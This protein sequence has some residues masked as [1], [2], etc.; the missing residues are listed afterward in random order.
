[1]SKNRVN[2]EQSEETPD[3]S[4]AGVIRQAFA[5]IEA[6]REAGISMARIAQKLA[7]RSC[8]TSALQMS[9][10]KPTARAVGARKRMQ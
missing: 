3:Q 4:K 6:W 1:M 9:T 2:I 8:R 10:V 5:E 7:E